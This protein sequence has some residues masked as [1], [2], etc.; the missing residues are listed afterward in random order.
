MSD[1]YI[2]STSLEQARVFHKSIEEHF[3][4]VEDCRRERS[5]RHRLSHILFIAICGITSG[6]NNLKA[7]VEYAQTKK[8]WLQSILDL[9]D[10]IPSYPTFWLF[11]ALLNPEAL[12]RCFAEWVQAMVLHSKGRL[13]ALDGKA[14]RGTSSP[15]SANSFVHISHSG[16][17]R[18]AP[19]CEI[20]EHEFTEMRDMKDPKWGLCLMQHCTLSSKFVLNHFPNGKRQMIAVHKMCFFV[21]F[22][23]FIAMDAQSSI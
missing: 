18:G 22:C 20:N 17:P 12:S 5:T 11:F 2:E 14:Q 9:T 4:E 8:A 23:C 6:C 10:G 7:V 13:I 3:S 21:H 19:E 16:A 15:N 1:D